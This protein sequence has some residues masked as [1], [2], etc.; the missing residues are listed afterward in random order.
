MT[1]LGGSR[2]LVSPTRLR[3]PRIPA[4]S[5]SRS[6]LVEKALGR[7]ALTVVCAPAGSGKTM[8]TADWATSLE[9]AGH[10][11]AWLTVE[12]RDDRPYEFWSAVIEACIAAVPEDAATSLAALSPPRQG[13]EPGFVT[14]MTDAIVAQPSLGYLVL[15]DVHRLQHPEVLAG[16][17]RFVQLACAELG[18]VLVC[19]TEPRLSLPRWRLDGLVADVGTDDLAFTESEADDLLAALDARIPR[20]AVARLVVRTEGWA[21]G[22]R[23]AAIHLAASDDPAAFLAR[24]EGDQRAVADYLSAE[25]IQHLPQDLRDFLVATCAPEQLSIELAAS[26]TGRPDAG[27]VLDNL[28]RSNAL[29]VQSGDSS[30]YR[31]HSLLRGYLLSALERRDVQGPSRQHA[32]TARWFADHDEPAIAL[33]HAAQSGD[34]H[35]LHELIHRNGLRL[36][37][38]GQAAMVRDTIGPPPPATEDPCVAVVAALAALDVTDLALAD[39]WLAVVRGHPPGDDPSYDALRASAI[40]QR[41]LLGGDVASAL[42]ESGILELAPTED[43]DVDLM[44]MAYRAAARMRHGDYHGAVSDLRGALLIARSHRYDQVVLWTLSQLAGM[45]AALCEFH[46]SYEWSREAIEF[47][48]HR[49]WVESPRLAYAYLVAGWTDYQTGGSAHSWHA[50]HGIRALDGVNNVEVETAVRCLQAI[51]MADS[52]VGNARRA[53]AERLHQILESDVL[54]QV[55]P[56]LNS[57]ASQQAIRVAIDV[58]RPQW[59]R[60]SAERLQ[61]QLPDS[62]ESATARATLLASRGLARE[63]LD[64]LAPV[65]G[66]EVPVHV[67]TTTVYAQLL[68]ATLEASLGNDHRAFRALEHAMDWAAPNNFKRPFLDAWHD[69]EPLLS[70]NRGRFGTAESFVTALIERQRSTDRLSVGLVNHTLTEREA[71]VLRELPSVLT[72][73]E[74]ADAQGVTVNTVKTHI[75]AI[76]RKLGVSG[77]GEA[78]REAR[79]RGML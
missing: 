24:F 43:P 78:V 34:D 58:G 5:V 8:A 46:A 74:I 68:A 71:E 72:A 54:E 55:S 18:I 32:C 25:I 10:G 35:L 42:S 15:D 45:S 7:G 76:Y 49:G 39:E 13:M 12:D 29:V 31:Y 69:L 21:A 17:D 40:V 6:R 60:E 41:S 26:L 61:R 28:C 64:L 14:A 44:V 23:L 19:R 4:R 9:A 65:L 67:P 16:L 3:I 56:A 52:A 20:A 48:T 75:Q 1:K 63:A 2:A 22:I 36:V 38:S 47:A 27:E 57:L 79:A 66:G 11:V 51:V 37:L 33:D 77:R 50:R 70:Q 73:K 53:A 59:A 30:W 62:A